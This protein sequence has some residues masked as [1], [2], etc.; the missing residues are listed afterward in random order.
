MCSGQGRDSPLLHVERPRPAL[1]E[2]QTLAFIIVRPVRKRNNKQDK[3]LI[4]RWRSDRRR[5]VGEWVYA[6]RATEK[7]RKRVADIFGHLTLRFT[8]RRVYSEFKGSCDVQEYKVLASDSDQLPY[9]IGTR[10]RR[11]G[12]SSTCTS[13]VTIIGLRWGEIGS[14]FGE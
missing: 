4:G 14:S 2:A 1:P 3:R 10:F 12:G 9:H 11:S 7:R 8:R 6:R 13:R 5:T